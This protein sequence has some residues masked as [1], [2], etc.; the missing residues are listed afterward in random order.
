MRKVI[1]TK[2]GNFISETRI[3]K[4]I[5]EAYDRGDREIEIDGARV[6]MLT[7]IVINNE[8][9]IKILVQR[10]ENAEKKTE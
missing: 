8:L 6:I 1:R 10:K 3:L 5:E 2:D 4:A 9:V 7:G